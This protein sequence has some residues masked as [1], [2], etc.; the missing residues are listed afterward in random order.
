MRASA[1]MFSPS[2]WAAILRSWMSRLTSSRF[3]VRASMRSS[4]VMI[5]VYLRRCFRDRPL[6]CLY[7]LRKDL[8]ILEPDEHPLHHLL[9]QRLL[10]FRRAAI[11]HHE[12]RAVLSADHLPP[13][14][15][16]AI[17]IP[18]R[19]SLGVYQQHLPQRL[20]QLIQS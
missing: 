18:R 17:A 19:L 1:R 13:A 3:M 15:P 10:L 8:G 16:R 7:P 9:F 20:F 4:M 12:F 14:I 2:C 5:L 11:A 6:A